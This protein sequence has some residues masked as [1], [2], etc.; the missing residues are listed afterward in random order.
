MVVA[1]SVRGGLTRRF[2]VDVALLVEAAGMNAP[3]KRFIIRARV[4][5]RVPASRAIDM[6]V[7]KGQI[8]QTGSLI[9]AD[10]ARVHP[11]ATGYIQ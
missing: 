2:T 8:T 9:W 6:P 5:T 7:I 11:I 10:I 4:W 3:L 1:K